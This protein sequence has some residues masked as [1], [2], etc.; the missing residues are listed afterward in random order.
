M[1]FITQFAEASFW[2][3][4]GALALIVASGCLL[5]A[6][7]L[8]AEEEA[9]EIYSAMEPHSEIPAEI[10]MLPLNL[11]QDSIPPS[12]SKKEA[13]EADAFTASLPELKLLEPQNPKTALDDVAEGITE[14][15]ALSTE[16]VSEGLSE[17]SLD[18]SF[19]ESIE[20]EK[21][22][23]QAR[24]AE[25]ARLLSPGKLSHCVQESRWS[26]SPVTSH[27][28]T[29]IQNRLQIVTLIL[30]RHGRAYDYR[31]HTLSELRSLLADLETS[32]FP[33]N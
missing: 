16:T 21:E 7:P 19:E 17:A 29:D 4:R 2:H 24:S 20:S 3:Q 6:P 9:L 8:K 1:N 32:T 26:Y 10:E 15:E 18:A 28:K 30:E 13:A 27:R 22:Q 12:R 33:R 5:Y 31:V 23:S 14:A 11:S 25:V